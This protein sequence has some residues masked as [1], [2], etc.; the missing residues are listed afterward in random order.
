MIHDPKQQRLFM[1]FHEL[2]A[3]KQRDLITECTDPVQEFKWQIYAHRMIKAIEDEIEWV[4]RLEDDT[5]EEELIRPYL[6]GIRK[7]VFG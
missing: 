7:E 4:M 5:P 3:T 1:L 6:V 2:R